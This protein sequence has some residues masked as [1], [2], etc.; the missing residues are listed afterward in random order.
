MLRHD[1]LKD[2][3]ILLLRPEGALRAD[4]FAAVGREVDEYLTKQADLNGVLIQAEEFLRFVRQ[5]HRN[6]KRVALVTDSSLLTIM[7]R[8]A[9]HFVSAQ[10]RTFGSGE[11]GEAMAWLSDG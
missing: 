5:H 8:I 4:D 10:V 9:S 1:I 11:R 6:I 7:P 2:K 3:G